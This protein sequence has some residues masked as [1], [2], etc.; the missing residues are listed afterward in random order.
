MARN[1]VILLLCVVVSALPLVGCYQ[2]DPATGKGAIGQARDE[3]AKA[4]EAKTKAKV[5][6][7]LDEN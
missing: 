5:N 2:T 6:K 3:H 7:A 4:E 1:R